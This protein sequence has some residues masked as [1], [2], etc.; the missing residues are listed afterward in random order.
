MWPDSSNL[1]LE[2]HLLRGA[3]RAAQEGFLSH[4]TDQCISFK[5]SGF[6]LVFIW[7]MTLMVCCRLD[8]WAM[9]LCDR[10]VRRVEIFILWAKGRR[11]YI[12]KSPCWRR[13][14]VW[15]MPVFLQRSWEIHVQI[16]YTPST[17]SEPVLN[18]T[19]LQLKALYRDILKHRTRFLS[20][21]PWRISPWVPNLET[22]LREM[23]FSHTIIAKLPPTA[24]EC[25]LKL[26]EM[27]G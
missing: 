4:A 24:I 1:I 5:A 14:E 8:V 3:P 27:S 12:P 13:L 9:Q 22:L 17:S 25:D 10:R 23:A 6:I 11:L 20:W 16:D 15:E 21:W 19:T 7:L 2:C 26:R 18:F